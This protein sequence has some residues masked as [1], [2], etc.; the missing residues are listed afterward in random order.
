MRNLCLRVCYMW[1]LWLYHRVCTERWWSLSGQRSSMLQLPVRVWPYAGPR[2]SPDTHTHTAW[3]LTTT[4]VVPLQNAIMCVWE[5][6][7]D[8]SVF[9]LRIWS[10]LC[11]SPLRSAGPPARMKE[12]KIPSPSSPPTMLNPRPVEP[13]WIKTLRGSLEKR[14]RRVDSHINQVISNTIHNIKRYED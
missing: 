1:Q 4:T 6:Y 3:P 13:L 2:R 5:L 10:P 11:S 8:K 14:W 9:T 12:I 7:K